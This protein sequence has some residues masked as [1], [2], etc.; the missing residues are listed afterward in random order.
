MAVVEMKRILLAAVGFA[1]AWWLGR[2]GEKVKPA[3]ADKA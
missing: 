1:V 2:W 3:D